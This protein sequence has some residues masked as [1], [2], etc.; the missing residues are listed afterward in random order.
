MIQIRYDLY[1]KCN[2]Q[3]HHRSSIFVSKHFPQNPRT[4]ID[5]YYEIL[6]GITGIIPAQI[7]V[8]IKNFKSLMFS[9]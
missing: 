3:I 9:C 1:V 4:T 8:I 5:N 2:S 6:I 7:N